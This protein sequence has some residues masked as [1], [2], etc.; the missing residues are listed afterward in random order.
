L[1][2]LTN[3]ALSSSP[4]PL[5]KAGIDGFFD[6]NFN[7]SD[8]SAFKPHP[9]TYDMVAKY[10]GVEP[11]QMCMVACHLW[12]IIGAQAFGCRGGFV[13]RPHNSMLDLQ[14]LPKPDFVAKN[15][16]DLAHQIITANVAI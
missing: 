5:E 2:T 12:D 1:V 3:S 13:A 4:T 16:G 6:N 9:A 7:L 8:V 11:S 14:N 15:L 10:Y